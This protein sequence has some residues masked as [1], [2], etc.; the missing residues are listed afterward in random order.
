[1]E[2]EKGLDPQICN[3]FREAVNESPTLSQEKERLSLYNL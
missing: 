1:M 2:E 3:R